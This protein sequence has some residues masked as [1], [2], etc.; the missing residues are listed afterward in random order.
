MGLAANVVGCMGAGMGL[1][2]PVGAV[3]GIGLWALVIWGGVTLARRSGVLRS[4]SRA[5]QTLAE[6]YAAGEIDDDEYRERLAT[7][8]GTATGDVGS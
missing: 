6:R 5:E 2:A 8:A 7:L 1:W 3:L 4:G